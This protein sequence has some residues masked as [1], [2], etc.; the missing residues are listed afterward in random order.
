[1]SKAHGSKTVIKVDT[2][3]ISQFTDAS[4]LTRAGDSHNTTTYGNTAHRKD[5]GLTDGKFTMAGVWD[6]AVGTGVD[7]V[8]SPLQAQKAV[9]T[10]QLEGTGSG[11]KQEKF[12]AVM[13]SYVTSAPVADFIRWTSEWELDGP[14]DDTPQT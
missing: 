13:T 3:D 11:K 14:I 6:S 9:I 5:G 8:L 1:M 7:D 12:T 4:E 2:D 10:R